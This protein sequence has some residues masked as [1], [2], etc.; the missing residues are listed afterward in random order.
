M[1]ECGE[2]DMILSF[3]E[4]GDKKESSMFEDNLYKKLSWLNENEF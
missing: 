4:E 2:Y 1:K 3:K